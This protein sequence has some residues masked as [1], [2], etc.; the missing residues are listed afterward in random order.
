MAEN[1]MQ[2]WPSR[3]NHPAGIVDN[4]TSLEERGTEGEMTVHDTLDVAIVLTPGF[5]LMVYAAT[6]EP[7]RGVNSVL[8]DTRYRWTT[9]SPDGGPVLS[10]SGVEVQTSPLPQMP[11]ADIGM[12]VICGGLGTEHDENPK[13]RSF[14]RALRRRNIVIGA[15]ST[16]S[17]ILAS[18]GMLDERRCTVNWDAKDSFRERFPHLN[19]SSDLFVIDD[20]V[21]TCAGGTGTLDVILH[22]IRQ[23]EGDRVARLVSDMFTHGI[24]RQANDAQRMSIRNR[25]GVTQPIV[26]KS[27]E[28]MERSVEDPVSIPDIARQVRVSARQLERLFH[29]H[30]GRSPS[31][32]Y[33]GVR[34]EVARRLLRQS[35]MPVIEIGI[36]CGFTSASHFGRIYRRHFGLAPSDD[37]EPRRVQFLAARKPPTMAPGAWSMPPSV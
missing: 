28:L 16:G 13:L 29:R 20:G 6:V 15:V 37:R 12:L 35:T 23:R 34:L 36:A 30:L 19:L 31:Q 3:V 5:S 8:N 17:F 14:L 4:T 10:S 25:L 1:I 22:F 18:A 26:V 32:Y 24:I 27:V 21:F 2:C 7:L 33:V 11:D 9:L